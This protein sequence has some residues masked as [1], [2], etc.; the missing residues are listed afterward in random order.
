MKSGAKP[1]TGAR[2]VASLER[3]FMTVNDD[4][5]VGERDINVLRPH[6]AEDLIS[7]SDFE[8]DERLPYWAEL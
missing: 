8:R 1:L 6:S 5:R 7:E 2:L 3:R 4:V